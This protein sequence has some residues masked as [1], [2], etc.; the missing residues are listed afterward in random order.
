MDEDGE[1]KT[2]PAT[3][4]GDVEDEQQ[5]TMTS[6]QLEKLEEVYEAKQS[7]QKNLFLI[8]FQRFIMVLTEH[9]QSCER[10]RKTFKNYWFFWTITRL[11]QV[12][13]E[14]TISVELLWQIIET[15]WFSFYSTTCISSSLST[16]SKSFSSP[17]TSTRTFCSS[18]DNFDRCALEAFVFDEFHH[19]IKGRTYLADRTDHSWNLFGKEYNL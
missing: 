11:Q 5:E 6:E 9:I 13:F 4:G 16:H 17:A 1:V 14:V 10:Q 19:I 12:F 3:V 8:V 18:S 2:E 7:E 15:N